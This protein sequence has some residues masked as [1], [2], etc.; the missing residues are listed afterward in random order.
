MAQQTYSSAQR[1]AHW[2]VLFLVIFQYFTGSG[3]EH[4]FDAVAESGGSWTGTAY[5]HGMIGTTILLTMLFRLYLRST[6]GAPPPPDTEPSAI[7]WISRAN[8]FLFYAVLI[9]MPLAGLYAAL[10]LSETAAW[11]HG[12]AWT[13]LL[14]LIAAHVA[15]ALWHVSKGDGVLRRMA[16]RAPST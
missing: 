10:T 3:M 11:L 1:G 12:N 16:G 13:V 14:V 4:A 15:G 7:Q 9:A 5:V 6:R 2:L 8:H